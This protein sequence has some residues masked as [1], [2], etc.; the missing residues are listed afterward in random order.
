MLTKGETQMCSFLFYF[1]LNPH[2]FSFIRRGFLY[3]IFLMRC[4]ITSV[5][6]FYYPFHLVPSSTVTVDLDEKFKKGF[7]QASL[8]EVVI[9][10]KWHGFG[11]QVSFRSFYL[12]GCR[13]CPYRCLQGNTLPK[14]I[15]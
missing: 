8:A 5:E 15:Y 13:N 9:A 1:Y 4:I 10:I 11:S 2:K 12:F 7:V 3:D 14:S 6:V